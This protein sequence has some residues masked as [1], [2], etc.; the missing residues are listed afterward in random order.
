[1]K[2]FFTLLTVVFFLFALPL[3][4]V[5]QE[6]LLA[7]QGVY[8]WVITTSVSFDEAIPLLQKRIAD[9]PFRLLAIVSMKSPDDCTYRSNVFVLYDSVYAEKLLDINPLTAPFA[10]TDRINLFEDENGVHVSV[11]NPLNI[12]R[13]VLLND[14]KY[15]TLSAEHLKALR[16]VILSA[17]PGK[18]LKKQYGQFRKKGYIGRTM[19]VMAGGPFDEKIQTIASRKGG[20]FTGILS[21]LEKGLARPGKKWGLKAVYFLRIPGRNIAVIGVS[22]EEMESRSFSIVKAGNDKTRKKFKCPGIAH[23]AAYPIEVVVRQVNDGVKVQMV[24]AMYRMKMFFEDAGKWAF[25]KN[26]TMPGSIQSEIK[27]QIE[28]ALSK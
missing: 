7:E 8:E 16:E 13:T 18:E 4:P 10:L 20:D 21:Q 19:G 24:D 3:K 25:A 17:L 27:E 26:M 23:A 2:T 11:V 14:E 28:N 15:Q 9:S 12:N 1:M 22:G 5:A 6:T